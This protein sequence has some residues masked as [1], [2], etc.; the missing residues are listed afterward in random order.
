MTQAGTTPVAVFDLDGTITTHDTLRLFLRRGLSGWPA[1]PWVAF[2]LP[3]DWLAAR[4]DVAARGA[5]K[6]RMLDTVFGGRS[7]AWLEDFCRAFVT[8]L[9][10]SGI[11]AGAKAA[12]ARHRAGGHRLLLATASPELWALPIGQALGFDAVLATRLAW[13]AENFAGR[14]DGPNLLHAEKSRA[15]QRWMA[16]Q[17][18]GAAPHA[19]YTDHHH[20]LPMLLLAENPVAVDPTPALAAE[21]RA[22]GIPIETWG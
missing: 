21:A 9:L 17:A 18:E 20:D 16:D 5:F 8:D 1:R 3:A 7:R 12:I 6:A 15:V 14:L 19:A 11:K 22:R 4:R 10:A 2:G 13:Q